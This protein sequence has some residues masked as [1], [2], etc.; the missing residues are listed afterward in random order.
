MRPQHERKQVA[1]PLSEVFI[2]LANMFIV[3]N[4]LRT[5]PRGE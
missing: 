5:M 3:V 4:E 2:R 1:V